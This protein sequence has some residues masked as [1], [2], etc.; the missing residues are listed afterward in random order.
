[1]TSRQ[2]TKLYGSDTSLGHDFGWKL[3]EDTNYAE[4]KLLAV[5]GH[6]RGAYAFRR[7]ALWR[8]FVG[9]GPGQETE[10]GML[11]FGYYNG[12][13]AGCPF[14]PGRAGCLNGQ[15]LQF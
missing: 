2:G 14:I 10:L 1:M 4:D 11:S 13:G 8:A 6:R 9:K 15:Q 7:K 12:R 3:T 5:N